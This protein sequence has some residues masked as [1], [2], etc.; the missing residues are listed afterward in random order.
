HFV[1]RPSELGDVPGWSGARVWRHL[2]TRIV[3]LPDGGPNGPA[4]GEQES[5]RQRSDVSFRA[6]H[7]V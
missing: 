3:E 6:E 1:L 5:G 7:D 2:W 4:D